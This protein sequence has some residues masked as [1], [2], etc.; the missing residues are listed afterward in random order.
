MDPGFIL[1]GHQA[2]AGSRIPPSHVVPLPQ[3]KGPALPPLTSLNSDG[4]QE[5]KNEAEYRLCIHRFGFCLPIISREEDKSIIIDIGVFQC[6]KNLTNS[7]IQLIQS[8]SKGQ[9]D[10]G[11]SELLAGKLRVVSMLEG[12][13]EEEWR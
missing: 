1:D 9:S 13:V 3:R 11:I 2:I 7:P 5:K 12:H 6:L 10:A 4:L 8:I